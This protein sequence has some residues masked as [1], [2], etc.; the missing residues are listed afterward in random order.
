MS[1]ASYMLDRASERERLACID[2]VVSLCASQ[3]VIAA[4]TQQVK[5]KRASRISSKI[6]VRRRSWKGEEVVVVMFDN[7]A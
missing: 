4:M 1:L 7:I 2:A 5:E 3:D 6:Q